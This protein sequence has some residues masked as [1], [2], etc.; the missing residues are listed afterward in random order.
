MLK[1]IEQ[2]KAA[3]RQKS[4]LNRGTKPPLS[5]GDDNGERHVRTADVVGP[6]V[7]LSPRQFTRLAYIDKEAKEG[8]NT[9]AK[10]LDDI[11]AR[12]EDIFSL[13]RPMSSLC[14]SAP[15]QRAG[16]GHGAIWRDFDTMRALS[17]VFGDSCF[18]QIPCTAL[19]QSHL[20]HLP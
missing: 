18:P 7:G 20:W 3:A 4:G 16:T 9:A 14:P 19:L 12:K 8:N 1:E 13:G 10:I 15:P 11:D 2:P 17:K 5:S 6:A